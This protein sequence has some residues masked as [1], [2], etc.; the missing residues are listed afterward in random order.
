MKICTESDCVALRWYA[1]RVQIRLDGY[2]KSISLGEFRG[3]AENTHKYKA[4][5]GL[6]VLI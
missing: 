4:S 5:W 1:A 6:T 2:S 3:V